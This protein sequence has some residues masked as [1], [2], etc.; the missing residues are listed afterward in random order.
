MGAIEFRISIAKSL[1]TWLGLNASSTWPCLCVRDLKP[2]AWSKETCILT[3]LT[4]FRMIGARNTATRMLCLNI[5]ENRWLSMTSD[6]FTPRSETYLVRSP[7]KSLLQLKV[8]YVTHITSL[9]LNMCLKLLMPFMPLH[10]LEYQTVLL[11]QVA[12]TYVEILHRETAL[13]V[14]PVASFPVWQ[15]TC[16]GQGSK[17]STSKPRWKFSSISDSPSLLLTFSL[18]IS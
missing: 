2:S 9:T 15:A 3:S 5:W 18:H 8:R 11:W 7:T 4:S 16:Q 12:A 14:A 17:F 6:W 10:I 1:F 13:S